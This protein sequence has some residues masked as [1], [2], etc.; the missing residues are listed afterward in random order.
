VAKPKP[1]AAHHQTKRAEVTVEK[2]EV[3]AYSV[4]SD[5]PEADG[6][7]EWDKTT[8]VLAEATGG[9]LRSVGYTYA[10]TATAQLITDMLAPV[11]AGRDALDIEGACAP[12]LHAH[13]RCAITPMRHSNTSMTMSESST[14]C[15]TARSRRLQSY[16]VPICRTPLR[17]G[18]HTR[19]RRA[20]RRLE[21]TR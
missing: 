8:L 7:L 11:V 13:L 5:F 17:T 14:C 4:P 6:T 10:D 20:V 18:I 15:S 19:R 12:S 21:V 3:S 1:N 2:L 16:C 9:D